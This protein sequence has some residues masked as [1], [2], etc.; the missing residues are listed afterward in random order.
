MS[1]G[2]HSGGTGPSGTSRP[3]PLGALTGVAGGW[4]ALHA[5][6]ELGVLERLADAPARAEALADRVGLEPRLTAAVL[7]VLAAVGVAEADADGA[8][9]VTPGTAD[10][11]GWTEGVYGALADAWRGGAGPGYDEPAG[12][13]AHYPGLVERLADVVTDVA[14]EFAGWL[15]RPGVR[16]L[17][18]GAG[19]APWSLAMVRRE[20]SCR[21]TALDLP[22]VA[23]VTRR[24]VAEASAADRY[25]IIDADAFSH[26]PGGPYDLVVAG[27]LC[28]LFDDATAEALVVR[29]AGV[30][31]GGGQLAIIDALADDP[32][33]SPV[34]RATY[35]LGLALR[36]T[37]GR[38]HTGT[39]HRRWLTTA[40]LDPRTAHVSEHAPHGLRLHLLVGDVGV[41]SGLRSAGL[42]GYRM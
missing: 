24:A 34:A 26:L 37:G 7:E 20:P 16:V 12:A 6:R 13:A 36:T 29:L 21:V 30:L 28:H 2:A 17:D 23:D 18:V 1:A 39:A 10:V 38:L 27:A 41:P 32:Q 3:V 14:D 42:P 31:A 19:A 9:R 8:Y 22:G 11:T 40:G 33:T 35:E 5:A 25:E 15:A 4:A